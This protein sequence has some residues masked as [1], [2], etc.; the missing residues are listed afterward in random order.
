MRVGKGGRRPGR[1]PSRSAA[2]PDI[3]IDVKMTRKDLPDRTIDSYAGALIA[4]GTMHGKEHQVAPAFATTLRARVVAP[5]GIDTDQFGTF[6]GEVT[7]AKTPLAAATAKARIAMGSADVPYGLAS[8]ASYHTW[9]GM[10]AMHEEILVFVDDTR[11]IRVFEGVNVPGAPG[12]PTV[13]DTADDAVRAAH[14][15]GFPQQGAI[16]KTRIGGQVQVF[17]KGITDADTLIQVVGAAMAAGDHHSVMVE[18]DLRAHHN[19]TRRD[20][21]TTL[22]ARLANRLATHCPSCSCPGYGKVAVRE[23]LAC[24]TCGWPTSVVSAD[25]LACPACEHYARVERNQALADPRHCPQCN[26]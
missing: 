17:G 4:M 15:F 10:A 11:D 6:A 12:P 8:E 9:Y 1:S 13:V 23:G 25:I 22:A 26:P 3:G 20:V 7:R 16:V 2:S 18:P 19:P 24:R 5:A 21:L 14:R